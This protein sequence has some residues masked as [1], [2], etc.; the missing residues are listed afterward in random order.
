MND[1]TDLLAVDAPPS[2][3]LRHGHEGDGDADLVSGD[4]G[5]VP[6]AEVRGDLG[7]AAGGHALDGVGGG[8]PRALARGVQGRNLELVLHVLL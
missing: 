6:Q 8:R 4:D 7:R 5:H 3:W 1:L 2:L